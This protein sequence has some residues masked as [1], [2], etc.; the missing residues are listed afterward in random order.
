[1]AA[2]VR[3]PGLPTKYAALLQLLMVANAIPW[4][5]K[6]FGAKEHTVIQAP[7]IIIEHN[8]FSWKGPTRIV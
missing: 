3:K 2:C 6:D 1:M 7:E 8:S 5:K 4:W